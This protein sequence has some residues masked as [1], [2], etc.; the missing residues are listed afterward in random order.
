MFPSHS[1]CQSGSHFW[2]LVH[3]SYLIHS[4]LLKMLKVSFK[5][6][7]MIIFIIFNLTFFSK[8]INWLNKKCKKLRIMSNTL[9]RLF[10]LCLTKRPKPQNKFTMWH[11]E[12]LT[13]K[14]LQPAN[15]QQPKGF[16]NQ[17]SYCQ[18]VFCWSETFNFYQE[19][20]VINP[21]KL[22]MKCKIKID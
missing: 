3:F 22:K 11:Q 2:S 20:L 18:S 14:N 8:L 4:R 12:I 13:I 19:L 17:R 15:I 9:A 16:V 5:A 7:I 6:A 1:C 10:L 21:V